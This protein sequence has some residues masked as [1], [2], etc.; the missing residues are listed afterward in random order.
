MNWAYTYL[1]KHN[2]AFERDYPYTSGRGATGRCDNTKTGKGCIE[3][4]NYASVTRNS[5]SQLKAAI[6]KAV[7]SVA[8]QA[9]KTVFQMYKSGIITGS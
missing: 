1:E 6:Q 5:P 2:L 7:V 4:G 9:D 8:I 3:V